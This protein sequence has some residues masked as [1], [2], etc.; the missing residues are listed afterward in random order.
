VVVQIL[1]A[2]CQA[3][4]PLRHQLG[5]R[6]L[7]KQWTAPVQET[8]GQAGQQIQATIGFPKQQPTTVGGDG[9]AIESGY[10]L[11]RKMG[12]KLEPSVVSNK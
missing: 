12:C 4:D 5:N 2:Q 11:A 6:M 9:A 10:H 7:H 8:L 1:V 3:A